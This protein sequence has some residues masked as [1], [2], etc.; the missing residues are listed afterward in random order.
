VNIEAETAGTVMDVNRISSVSLAGSSPPNR[1]ADSPETVQALASAVR[2]LNSATNGE[3][4]FN[5]IRDP[6][7]HRFVV[8]LRDRT[9]GDVIDQFPPEIILQMAA[10]LS[11]VPNN[12]SGESTK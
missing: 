2:R 10:D 12:P 8:T 11:T 1:Q 3:G 6:Q 5:V 7:T 9:S 4:V